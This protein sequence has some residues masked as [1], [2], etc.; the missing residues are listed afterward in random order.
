MTGKKV[1]AVIRN[2]GSGE[3]P[4]MTE[5][6]GATTVD[7]VVKPRSAREGIG[8]AVGDRLCIA[9]NAPPVDGKANDAVV[10]VLA[11]TFHVPRSAITIVRGETGR[12]KTIRI[13]GV[14]AAVVARAM[15]SKP[16]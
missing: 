15:Q 4:R 14:A 11:E 5:K 3:M 7:V 9:V 6:D 16:A 12:K 1:E 8:P 10:R 13:V 2:Q